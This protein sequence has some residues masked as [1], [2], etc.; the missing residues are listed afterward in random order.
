MK[1]KETTVPDDRILSGVL[2]KKK[3]RTNTWVERFF[4]LRGQSLEYYIK[5]AD[6]V[7]V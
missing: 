7:I 5:P 2:R 1:S 6:S 3:S 4:V